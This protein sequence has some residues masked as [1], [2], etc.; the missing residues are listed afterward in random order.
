MQLRRRLRSGLTAELQ[1]TFAKSIDDA[2]LGGGGQ[3]GGLIAQDWLNLR[4]ERGRSNFDQR[5]VLSYTMAYTTG[6][7]LRGGSLLGGWR[8]ALLKEWTVSTQVNAATGLPLTPSYQGIVQGTGVSGPI[9]PDYTG[10]P[11]YDAPSGLSLNPAAYAAPASGHWGNAG[12][13]TITGPRQFSFNASM[14]RTFRLSDRFSGTLQIDSA[15]VL[16]HPTF[17]NWV[18]LISSAQFGL[19]NNANSMRSFQTTFR[20]RF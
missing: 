8:G 11:L 1:Y 19:P 15:N 18:T 7:G 16:N 6:M 17:P 10:A 3:G 13:N 2:S 9:R 12:S 20:L 4:G 5:H 14:A